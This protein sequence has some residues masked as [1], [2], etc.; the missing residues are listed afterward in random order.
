ML[1]VAV[2]SVEVEQEAIAVPV[3]EL[4]VTG[5]AVQV[6]STKP[7]SSNFTD[8]VIATTA[9]PTA[10]ETVAVNVM[11]WLA[12]EG[13]FDDVTTVTVAAGLTLYASGVL[14]LVE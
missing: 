3:A 5:C 10:A 6:P 1:C 9:V 11:G 4:N 2:A 13:L 12:L 7:P 14:L 8:C